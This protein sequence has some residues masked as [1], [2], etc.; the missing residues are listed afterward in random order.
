[1]QLVRGHTGLGFRSAFQPVFLTAVLVISFFRLLLNIKP[2]FSLGGL[3][4]APHT[5]PSLVL[6]LP[7]SRIPDVARALWL[8]QALLSVRS[9]LPNLPHSFG[10]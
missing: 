2:L 6:P 3:L 9:W 10:L 4:C 7:G 1:M 8:T 5:T